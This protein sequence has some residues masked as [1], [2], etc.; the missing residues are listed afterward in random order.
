[1][2]SQLLIVFSVLSFSLYAQD[3]ETLQPDSIYK[4]NH[5][6]SRIQYWISPQA[7]KAKNITCYDTLGRLTDYKLTDNETGTNQMRIVYHYDNKC[8][9][10]GY[11]NYD[12]IDSTVETVAYQFDKLNRVIKAV[13]KIDGKLY[14]IEKIG[15]HPWIETAVYFDVEGNVIRKDTAHF[16]NENVY[17]KYSGFEFRDGKKQTWNYTLKATYDALG[18]LVKLGN[19]ISSEYFYDNRGLLIRKESGDVQSRLITIFDYTYWK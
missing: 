2:T 6:K 3:R 1:M 13:H 7:S 16:E 17:N 14:E 8:R 4:A 12:D 19:P 15:Y 5:I 18:R 10:S 9:Q 11:T